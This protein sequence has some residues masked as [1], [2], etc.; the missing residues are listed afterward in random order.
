MN[1]GR[2]EFTGSEYYEN[3]NNIFFYSGKNIN[4]AYNKEGKSRNISDLS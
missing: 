1:K 4:L 2:F 3:Q